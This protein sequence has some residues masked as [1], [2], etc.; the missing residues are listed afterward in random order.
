MPEYLIKRIID[1]LFDKLEG[2]TITME[3]LG[4]TTD[5]SINKK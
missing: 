5:I 1:Y 3:Q 2:Y 4:V